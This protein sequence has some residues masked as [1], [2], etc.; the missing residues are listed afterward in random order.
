MCAALAPAILVTIFLTL[1]SGC[2]GTVIKGH[3][4]SGVFED[5]IAVF[6]KTESEE[7]GARLIF[8]GEQR[9]KFKYGGTVRVFFRPAVPETCYMPILQVRYDNCTSR[10]LAVF[11]GCY[12]TV[13]TFSVPRVN[14]STSP[15]FVTLSTPVTLDS[16]EFYI[17]VHLDHLPKPDAFRVKFVS[18]YTGDDLETVHVPLGELPMI[19]QGGGGKAVLFEK[20]DKRLQENNGR[21][22]PIVDGN[23]LPL[24]LYKPCRP[25][26]KY[27]RRLREHLMTEDSWNVWSSAFAPAVAPPTTTRAA[28]VVTPIVALST[29]KAAEAPVTAIAITQPGD[30]VDTTT[31]EP[32]N[33]TVIIDA[34]NSTSGNV[35]LSGAGPSL[36]PLAIGLTVGGSVVGLIALSLLIG[37]LISCCVRRR[38][39]SRKSRRRVSLPH[40]TEALTAS[41]EEANASRM[42]AEVVELSELVNGSMRDYEDDADEDSLTTVSS[43]GK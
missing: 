19:G 17:A 30:S 42:P 23:G 25:C 28:A 31:V 29:T 15:G 11:A 3:G 12:S 27:C 5:T 9:P 21:A 32:H 38:R 24:S 41:T 26:G 16:G 35:T 7:V 33:T 34:Y 18:L 13:T 40:E 14:R 36:S 20:V 43:K 2:M 37:I 6:E 39:A 8:L 4:V 10:S 1:M 22:V